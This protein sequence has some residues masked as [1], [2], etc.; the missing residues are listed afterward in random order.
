M[1][2]YPDYDETK[3]KR[4]QLIGVIA[5]VVLMGALIYIVFKAAGKKRRK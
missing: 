5:I 2:V 3:G 4:E 1:A